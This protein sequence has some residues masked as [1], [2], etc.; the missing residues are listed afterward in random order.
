MAASSAWLPRG[1]QAPLAQALQDS[2]VVCLLGPRQCGKSALAQRHDPARPYFTFDDATLLSA[3]AAD[4]AGFVAGLPPVVTLDEIQRAPDVLLAIKIAVDRDRRPGR[5][6]LTGSADLLLLPAVSESLAGR[7]EVV[8]LHPLTEAEKERKPGRFLEHLLDASL[9][10]AARS[11]E[12]PVLDVV[13]RLLEGGYPEAVQREPVRARQWHRAYVDALIARD[14]KDV[15]NLRSLD[16]LDTLLTLMAHQTAQLVNIN[17]TARHLGVRRETVE[18][19]LSALERLFLVRRVPAWH[20]NE[21]RRLIKTPKVHVADSGVAATL[22]GLS[23]NEW[24]TERERF[25]HVLESFVLQQLVAQAGWTDP[26][27]RFWHYRDKDQVEVDVVITRGRKVWGVEVKAGAT[28]TEADGRGL[29]RLADT[30]GRY[31][32]GGVLLHAGTSTLPTADPRV[33]AAPLAELWTH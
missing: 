26:E 30:A 17:A 1:A 18:N 4:P 3:A 15:T 27:L 28:V 21:A 13:R 10:P 33:L 16:Q 29:R 7:M 12:P 8:R 22:I 24:N 9:K 11:G 6:L 5:F 25:G 19:M 23:A 14:A 2:P 31:F 32:Q 20:R